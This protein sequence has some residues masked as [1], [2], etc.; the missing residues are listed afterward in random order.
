M[1]TYIP[2]KFY[3]SDSF[4][5]NVSHKLRLYLRQYREFRS[6]TFGKRFPDVLLKIKGE[7]SIF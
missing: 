3:Q 6:I 4:F 2:E 7:K 5:F 1:T